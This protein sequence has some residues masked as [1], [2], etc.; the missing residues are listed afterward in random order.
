MK[1]LQILQ[2]KWPLFETAQYFHEQ[3]LH[4]EFSKN[5]NFRGLC[6]KLKEN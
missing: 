1:L 4:P 5:L 3:I 6:C 2:L